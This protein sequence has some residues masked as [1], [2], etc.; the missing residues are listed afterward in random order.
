MPGSTVHEVLE[1]V[2]VDNSRL[3]G[4]IVDERGA[5]RKHMS[6]FIDGE[7]IRDRHTL[8]DAVGP[9]SE[10]YVMQALSGG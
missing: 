8:S 10:I 5:L 4:Y 1:L 9:H 6:I 3:R 2:F 7:L